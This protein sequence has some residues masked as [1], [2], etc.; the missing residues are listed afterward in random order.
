MSV[1]ALSELSERAAG[2]VSDL[3]E[4]VARL[5]PA[6]EQFVVAQKSFAPLALIAVVILAVVPLLNDS[7]WTLRLQDGM[8]FG[9]L[10]ISLNILVGTTG[11]ITF[12][13]A[14]FWG[15]GGYMIAIPFRDHGINP[16]YLLALPPVAGALCAFL[17]GLVVLRGLDPLDRLADGGAVRHVENGQVG[18]VTGRA[19]GRGSGFQPA[20]IA[21]VQHHFGAGTRESVGQ[22][23]ADALRG[24]GDED[25]A[26]V[27]LEQIET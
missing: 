5:G 15:V 21:A 22:C 8:A 12:G 19:Q 11:L 16:L 9:L 27:E 7:A 23:Q 2:R 17:V 14:M 1:A 3:R 13:H 24:A 10:C 25:H 26:A 18:R 20:R 6:Q 4:R